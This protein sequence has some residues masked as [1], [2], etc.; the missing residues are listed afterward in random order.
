M[1][2]AAGVGGGY[3]WHRSAQFWAR[4]SSSAAV[5]YAASR[6]WSSALAVFLIEAIVSGRFKPVAMFIWA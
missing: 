5:V 2:V 4:L 6:V 1:S 3:H